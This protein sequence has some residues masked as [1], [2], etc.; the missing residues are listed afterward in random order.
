MELALECVD[1]MRGV[2]DEMQ[3]ITGDTLRTLY[4]PVAMRAARARAA[5]RLR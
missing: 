5:R 2:L 4:P 1:V 3:F